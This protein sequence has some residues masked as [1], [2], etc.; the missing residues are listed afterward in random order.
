MIKWKTQIT[1]VVVNS[2]A[3]DQILLP[4][5]AV[6]VALYPIESYVYLVIL[7]TSYCRLINNSRQKYGFWLPLWYLQALLGLYDKV[8]D[9]KGVV[10]SRWSKKVQTYNDQKKTWV[11]SIF[12]LFLWHYDSILNLIHFTEWVNLG[13]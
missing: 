5:I 7:T 6:Y 13:P 1:T 10:R 12:P 4:T 3:P 11:V 8:E 2:G 9:T